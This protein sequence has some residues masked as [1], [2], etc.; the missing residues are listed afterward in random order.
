LDPSTLKFPSFNN[1]SDDNL[2]ELGA[3]AIAACSPSKDNASMLAFLH[4]TIRDGI[5]ELIGASLKGLGAMTGRQAR[6]ALGHEY[7]N[8]EFGWLP[9]VNDIRQI[10]HSIIHADSIMSQYERDSGKLVR[11]RFAFQPTKTESAVTLKTGVSPWL[12]ASGGNLWKNP[13]GTQGSVIKVN[14]TLKEQWF[15]GAFTYYIPPP[16]SIRD[17]MARQ[18]ITAKHLLGLSLT[19]D[20]L[21]S[22]APWSWAFDWFANASSVLQNWTNWAIDNQVLVYGYMMEHCV[23]TDTYTYHGPTGFRTE[24]V[25]VPDITLTSESKVRI[26]S[27]PYGFGLSWDNFSAQQKAIIIALGLNKTR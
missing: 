25:V 24:T 1:S 16:D 27:G 3:K 19:P 14:K 21:W 4:E 5:P 11:R 9:F 20:S 23:S 26:K 17:E 2:K 15:S 18:V 6:K 10:S 22:I 7:L 12:P 8:Y 13:I